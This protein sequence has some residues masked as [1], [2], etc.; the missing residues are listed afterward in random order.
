MRFFIQDTSQK[1]RNYK[2][3]VDWATS[4]LLR[5]KSIFSGHLLNQKNIYDS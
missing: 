3:Q 5:L 2:I 1:R 4:G